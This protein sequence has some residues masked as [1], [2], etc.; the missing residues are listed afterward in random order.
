MADQRKATEQNFYDRA[1]E[2][3]TVD[4]M[5]GFFEIS[6]G[7][8]RY[9]QLIFADSSGKRVLEY[10]CGLGG[11]AFALA[12]RGATVTG[13]DISDVAV[14]QA[15]RRATA[16]PPHKLTFVKADAE[17]LDF[18]DGSF[19]LVCG[20]GI[21][22][23]LDLQRSLREV[24]RVLSDGGRSVFYEPLGH[25]PLLN[26]YRLLTPQSH[27]PDEHPL[28]K[29]EIDEMKARAEFFDLFSVF[30]IPVLWMPGGKALLRASE[31][32]DRQIFRLVPP[33][34][35]WAATIVLEL[36]K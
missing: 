20:S 11:Q 27:T 3:G 4:T 31:W 35:W 5:Y 18:A 30:I 16:S 22:H 9:R 32:I 36:R 14:A 34:R 28:L 13:I 23:H 19:D 10:G 2:S 6:A 12:D 24:R 8:Q 21:L 7:V 17:C 33:L 25:N 1:Y 26:L 29:H 15:R